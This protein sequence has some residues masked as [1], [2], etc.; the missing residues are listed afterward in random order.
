VVSPSTIAMDYRTKYAEYPVLDIPK[1][2]IV[3]PVESK[4]IVS[5]SSE[6]FYANQVFTGNQPIVS[7]A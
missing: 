3:D 2:W 7:P 5:M 6:G 1:Y 4:V